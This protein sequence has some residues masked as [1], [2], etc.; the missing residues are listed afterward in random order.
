[1]KKYDLVLASSSPRRRT[2]L[3][4]AGARFIVSAPELDEEF[5]PDLSPESNTENTAM[6]K[7]RAVCG[8]YPDDPVL[9]ADTIVA[10]DG[11]VIGKPA[12]GEEAERML[13]SLSGRE[14]SVVTGVALAHQ[15]RG[16][17]WKS[18]VVSKVRFRTLPRDWIREYVAGGEPMDKAG[19]YAIQGGAA[20]W[21]ESYSGSYTNIIGLPMEMVREVMAEFGYDIF[22]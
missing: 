12:S 20:A 4:E 18:S 1:M 10:L 2:L 9:A 13:Q 15:G 7:A 21:I 17:Y 5:H 11:E 6:D 3:Q 22:I 19:A 14:H 8:L 16:V